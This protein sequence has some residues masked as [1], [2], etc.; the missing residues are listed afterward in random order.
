MDLSFQFNFFCLG[1]LNAVH[2]ADG[3]GG[4]KAR[5]ETKNLDA[6]HPIRKCEQRQRRNFIKRVDEESHLCNAALSGESDESD[7]VAFEDSNSNKKNA[8]IPEKEAKFL[9]AH[10]GRLDDARRR[11]GQSRQLRWR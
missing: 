9:Y 4:G 8:K 3:K 10:N 1:L 6:S 5:M 2:D 7:C 11:F